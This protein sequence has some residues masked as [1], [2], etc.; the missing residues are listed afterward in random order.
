M[1][2]R[3]FLPW[4]HHD[5]FALNKIQTGHLKILIYSF[6]IEMSC[7]YLYVYIWRVW[8]LCYFI[9]LHLSMWCTIFRAL[10]LRHRKKAREA[11]WNSVKNYCL[12]AFLLLVKKHWKMSRLINYQKHQNELYESGN[13][14]QVRQ[15]NWPRSWYKLNQDP[16]REN[17][18]AWI[19]GSIPASLWHILIHIRQQI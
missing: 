8:K 6:L 17:N 4:G 12:I 7:T 9:A 2:I 3:D 5:T 11:H 10:G 18:P 19:L 14:E 15:V 13:W 1:L 16:A